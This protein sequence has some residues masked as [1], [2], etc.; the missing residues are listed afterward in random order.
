[1][2]CH[3]CMLGVSHYCAVLKMRGVFR[4]Q[5]DSQP[6]GEALSAMR[7]CKHLC[8]ILHLLHQSCEKAI[9]LEGQCHQSQSRCIEKHHTLSTLGL[10]SSWA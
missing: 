5:C 6:L 1:M 2:L 8:R 9:L 4:I 7:V 3:P 10:T